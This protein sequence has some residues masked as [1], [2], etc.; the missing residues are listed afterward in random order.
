MM[1]WGLA[2]S[3]S[4]WSDAGAILGTIVAVLGVV[5]VLVQL[6]GAAAATRAQATI[7]FQ[8]AFRESADMRGRLMRSSLFIPTC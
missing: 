1:P 3:L 7:Q 5:L 6:R 8:Q 2:A 4:D